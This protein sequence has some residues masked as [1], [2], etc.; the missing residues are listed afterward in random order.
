MDSQESISKT[1]ESFRCDGGISRR[2]ID[3]RDSGIVIEEDQ[4]FSSVDAIFDPDAKKPSLPANDSSLKEASYQDDDGDT[5]LHLA[6]V[7]FTLNQVK[8]LIQ[9]C[10]INAINNMLQTPLHVATLANR[11]EIVELLL[12][13]GARLNV[14]DRRGNTPLH[15]ACQNGLKQITCIMLDAVSNRAT[16]DLLSLDQ[17]IEST[18]FDGETCLHLAASRN[19]IEIVEMLVKKYNANLA[20]QDSRSG[21]TILHKAII[22][23]NVERVESILKLETHCNRADFAGHKPSDTIKMLRN[24]RLTQSQLSRLVLIEKLV[25]DAIKQCIGHNGCC[26]LNDDILVRSSSSSECSDSDSS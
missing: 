19:E 16:P 14:H 3:W 15:L 2:S 7:G 8:D 9:I 5:I 11:P 1:S 17:H 22:D 26:S 4:Q 24:S 13:S 20:I 12:S 18:N 6:T 10:D 21:A 25:S 23:F